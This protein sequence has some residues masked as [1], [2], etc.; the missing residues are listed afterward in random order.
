MLLLRQLHNW[1]RL[2]GLVEKQTPDQFKTLTAIRS[3]RRRGGGG[4]E[5]GWTMKF[6]AISLQSSSVFDAAAYYIGGGGDVWDSLQVSSRALSERGK[7]KR[8]HTLI[9]RW[10]GRQSSTTC[11]F[12][13]SDTG[14]RLYSTTSF[15][16]AMCCF[17]GSGSVIVAPGH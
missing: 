3:R 10:P 11:E 13:R 2:W 1:L 16:C 8:R 9:V 6:L 12:T 4:E 15:S 17:L 7:C 14:A 5:K